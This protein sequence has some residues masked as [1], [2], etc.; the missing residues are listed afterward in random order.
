MRQVVIAATLASPLMSPWAMAADRIFVDGIE[1]CSMMIDGDSDR[2]YDCDE[3][4]VALTD[5]SLADT[6]ADGLPDGDEV[7]GTLDGLDLPAFGVKPRRKDILVEYD[8]VEDANGCA[9]HTHALTPAQYETIRQVYANAPVVNP[10]GSYGVNLVQDYGQGGVFTGGGLVELPN[11]YLA[12]SADGAPRTALKAIHFAANRTKYF[13]YATL[14]HS[15]SDATQGYSGASDWH[16][17]FIVATYCWGHPAN[18]TF[19]KRNTV[20]HELGHDLGLWHGGAWGNLCIKRPNYNSVMNYR[21]QL[22]GNDQDCDA[23]AED[24]TEH[25]SAAATGYSTGVRPPLDESALDETTGVCGHIPGAPPVD[26]NYNGVIQSALQL[27]LNPSA[28]GPT[29]QQTKCGGNGV[30]AVLTDH[31]DWAAMDLTR[32]RTDPTPESGD[33]TPLSCEGPQQEPT[34]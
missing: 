25:D 5:P 11:G 14:V 12:G 20:L 6:D 18:T 8:W 34:P 30:Y 24:E 29:E 33:M 26:W 17:D 31:D 3:T 15:F 22:A 9:L 19:M 21:F 27:D 10:D 1:D 2:L 4:L 16:D 28:G 32:V 13:H 23:I 7:L